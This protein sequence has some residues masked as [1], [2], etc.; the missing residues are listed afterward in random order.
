MADK[1]FTSNDL[2][3]F[4]SR[5]GLKTGAP[6]VSA[7]PA[8]AQP[9]QF[10]TD[11]LKNFFAQKNTQP[12]AKTMPQAKPLVKPTPW[13]KTDPVKDYLFGKKQEPATGAEP[14]I[15]ATD[16]GVLGRLWED[17]KLLPTGTGKNIG[18][19]TQSIFNPLGRTDVQQQFIEQQQDAAYKEETAG[20]GTTGKV[21][22]SAGRGLGENLAG[23]V[24][25]FN[26]A[27]LFG[28]VAKNLGEAAVEAPS[29]M[30]QTLG[31]LAHLGF[32][33]Q[34]A[35]GAYDAGTASV[36][37]F[38]N[39]D[40]ETGVRMAVS[41][42]ISGVMAR[43]GV[44]DTMAQQQV[45]AALDKQA[46]K[47]HGQKFADLK[48]QEKA[49][50]VYEA[51]KQMP[52]H[53][54]L[55]AAAADDFIERAKR[56]GL[57]PPPVSEGL[58]ERL[59]QKGVRPFTPVPGVTPEIFKAGQ[60]H[61]A[62]MRAEATDAN[63]KAAAEDLKAKASR[64]MA[65]I[66]NPAK[67]KLPEAP[68]VLQVPVY[69]PA[70]RENI[71]YEADKAAAMRIIETERTAEL[72]RQAREKQL[73]DDARARQD[74]NEQESAARA[75]RNGGFIENDRRPELHRQVMAELGEKAA[76]S[77]TGKLYGDH[78]AALNRM[79]DGMG[80]RDTEM[81][82]AMIRAKRMRGETL[83][84]EENA[85]LAMQA[86]REELLR[87][88][89]KGNAR[90][91]SILA[92]HEKTLDVETLKNVLNYAQR[93]ADLRSA[94]R[95]LDEQAAKSGTPEAADL[96]A[97]QAIDAQQMA[98][99][100]QT[101][102]DQA[103]AEQAARKEE[104][105]VVP[106]GPNLPYTLGSAT[107][108]H[109]ADGRALKARYA[110]ARLSQ[111]V[112]SHDPFSFRWN[113]KYEPRRMQPRDWENN[114]NARGAIIIDSKPENYKLGRY[115]TDNPTASEGP[116]MI[117]PDGRVAGGNSRLARMIRRLGEGD[118]KSI[119]AEMASQFHRFG[120]AMEGLEDESDP[121]VLVR[122]M[123]DVP[124]TTQD[125][126]MLGQELNRDP[127]IMGVTAEEQ[128]QMNADRLTQEDV[129]GI[130]NMMEEVPGE[131]SLRDV[132][133]HRSQQIL[134]MMVKRGII[135]ANKQAA[136]IAN[137]ELT[138]NAKR[139]LE[140]AI[141]GKVIDDPALV[142]TTPASIMN[143]ID[144]TLPALLRLKSAGGTWEIGDYLK[145]AMRQWKQI[146]SVR[147][148]LNDIGT[149]DDSL[150]DKFYN[151]EEYAGGVGVM[152][153][154][155]DEVRPKPHPVAYAI[156]KALEAKAT[157]YK[158][159][160]DDF[161]APAEGKQ[162]F[163]IAP[164]EPYEVFNDTIGRLG[165]VE[166][167][168]ADWAT[169]EPA[170]PEQ[171]AAV[172]K[173]LEP[174]PAPTK[175]EQK[176]AK[177]MTSPPNVAI[178]ENNVLSAIE[179]GSV[180]PHGLRELFVANPSTSA[181]ADLLMEVLGKIVPNAT[182][183]SLP[184]FLAKHV[185]D[186]RAGGEYTG[187]L[188][189]DYWDEPLGT[190][191]EYTATVGELTDKLQKLGLTEDQAKYV[192]HQHAINADDAS[193][194]SRG[195]AKAAAIA[196]VVEVPPK[197]FFTELYAILGRATNIPW[198]DKLSSD[199]KA[200]RFKNA[201]N[202]RLTGEVMKEMYRFF[203]VDF[204]EKR[205]ALGEGLKELFQKAD[206]KGTVKKG[207]AQFL[208]DGRAIVHLFEA[209]DPSTVLHEFTHVMRRFLVDEN[210]RAALERF[211][212]VEHGLWDEPAEERV[213]RGFE[214]YMEE[215]MA[216]TEELQ[217]LFAKM[218]Q[219]FREIYG[220]I[221]N[222]KYRLPKASPINI[223]LSKEARATFDRW[224]GADE[225]REMTPPPDA[226][227]EMAPPPSSL[228]DVVTA[229]EREEAVLRAN[230][231][232][233]I[234]DRLGESRL[235]RFESMDDA[236]A[237]AINNRL[238]LDGIEMYELPNGQA[239]ANFVPKDAKTLFQEEPKTL[240]EMVKR[241]EYIK[242]LLAKETRPD[243]RER[244]QADIRRL[245]AK[246]GVP[247][248][249]FSPTPE[250]TIKPM[251]PVPPD[252]RPDLK[253]GKVELLFG[254]DRDKET[255]R[256]GGRAD[257]S[258]ELQQPGR[259]GEVAERAQRPAAGRATERNGASAGDGGRSSL[260]G[261]RATRLATPERMRAPAVV[262]AD[263]WAA[264][265]KTLGMPETLPAPT[266]KVD[267]DIAA[268]L[269]FPGQQ[270]VVESTLS[271]LDQFDG[272]IIATPTGTGK[273]YTTLAVV[274]QM[275]RRGQADRVLVLTKNDSIINAPRKG[276]KEIGKNTFKLEVADLPKKNLARMQDGVYATTYATLRGRP[277]IMH[278]AWDLVMLDESAEAANWQESAQG[279]A[280]RLLNNAT[281]KTVYISATPFASAVE[282]GYMGK[283]GMW[284]GG[285]FADWAKQF[286]VVEGK[287]GRLT[288]GN[289]PKKLLKLREQLIERGQFVTQEK[290][291]EG[292]SANFAQVPLTPE[293]HETMRGIITAMKEAALFYDMR[294]NA[295]M[296][297]AVRGNM[298]TF[299]KS[300]L[301]RT[302]LPQTLEIAKKMR[303]QG[304]KVVIFSETRAKVD[305][306]YDFL[307]EA[308]AAS[309]GRL[310]RAIPKLPGVYE[311]IAK[312][313]G[314]DQVANFSGAYSAAREAEKEA[315]DSGAKPILFAT[316]GAGGVG[317]SLHDD[318][319][320]A[321]RAAIYLG[322]PWSGKMFDQA[323]GRAWRYGTKSN[324]FS[325][326]M[327][328]NAMP[329]TRMILTKVAPRL[330][331]LRAAVDGV[332][333]DPMVERMRN[334]GYNREQL[335][336]FQMGAGPETKI[337]D[338]LEM[339]DRVL[340]SNYAD[341]VVPS[342]ESAKHK[343]MKYP[344]QVED[345]PGVIQLFQSDGTVIV[346]DRFQTPEE[347]KGQKV[348]EDIA[349]T[350][351]DGGAVP[352]V[353]DRLS[354][355][356]PGVRRMMA[357]MI[358]P[359]VADELETGGEADP[360]AVSRI[361]WGNEL[362]KMLAAKEAGDISVNSKGQ[363]EMR[364]APPEHLQAVE[365][366]G[367][368][369]V[370]PKE[371]NPAYWTL[372]GRQ[373][374]V[375]VAT[376]A[377]VPEVG[378]KL[379][380]MRDEYQVRRSNVAGDFQSRYLKVLQE[381]R[382]TPQESRVLFLV[383]EGKLPPPNERIA[384]AAQGL[385]ELTLDA[386]RMLKDRGWKG[387]YFADG[388]SREFNFAEMSD[389]PRYAPHKHDRNEKIILKD[390]QTGEEQT[391]TLNDLL[392]K[393]LSEIKR[394]KIIATIEHNT[395]MKR[396]EIEDWIDAKRRRTP[397]AGNLERARQADLPFYR[398]DANVWM[399]YFEQLGEAVARADVFGQ[400]R[401]KLDAVA[402]QIPS[403]KGR[404]VVNQ[405]FDGL[406]SK[407]PWDQQ[408]GK[409]YS[410]WGTAEVLSKM[411]FSA[412]K[413][414]FHLAHTA[415]VMENVGSVAKSVFQGAFS[416]G[417]MKE[418]AQLAGVLVDQMKA[419]A[420]MEQAAGAKAAN[421]MLKY[422][423]FHWMYQFDRITA[424][425]A[426][427]NW[428]ERYAL[429]KLMKKARS[430]D[431]IRTQ[432]KEKFLMDDKSIDA[433]VERGRW[434][435]EDLNRG[436]AALT[437][438]T[439]F[440][441]DPTELAPAW[442]S[443]SKEPVS[444]NLGAV[445]RIATILKGFTFKTAMLIKEDILGEARRGNY[446]PLMYAAM[447]YPAVGE[448]LQGLSAAARSAPAAV[449][450]NLHHNALTKYADDLSD[451]FTD[452]SV[453]KL[454]HRW[455]DD[456]GH[457]TAL[458]MVSEVFDT[459][460]FP[461]KNK[462]AARFK[463][464]KLATDE[465]FWAIGPYADALKTLDAAYHVLGAFSVEEGEKRFQVAGKATVGWAK[466]E[467]PVLRTVFPDKKST[468]TQMAPPPQ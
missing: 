288:G 258:A 417:E 104:K 281:V 466:E 302:R 231:G 34:M 399:E 43:S 223:E 452:P 47:L 396:A 367:T 449:T 437:N 369:K 352:A 35:T 250:S 79:T 391:F 152:T 319:G 205:A 271:A 418:R 446:R 428:M 323:M 351:T 195:I 213:A 430:A 266:V 403:K 332:S 269:I 13:A 37:A 263:K 372:S 112:L 158:R 191:G 268:L 228:S 68:T 432:L 264:R 144:R 80:F 46:Q 41:G 210:D 294:G 56:E 272:T 445:V 75:A 388:E 299:V 208:D 267:N 285:Q 6:A 51:A 160:F 164:P 318:R 192:L 366:G 148:S 145:E 91:E 343:G 78:I 349:Q 66:P 309:D 414:P 237:W 447:V 100:V 462:R 115:L 40:Y 54:E 243:V 175:E 244:M 133:R 348:N 203:G 163:L 111:L 157:E 320:N 200:G 386:Q 342:A 277:D 190:E 429:P 363:W 358:G 151:P 206:K 317:V 455:L 412:V 154:G 246:I 129:D 245:D 405:I 135:P 60:D 248:L 278:Q 63:A 214:K 467:F 383:K 132:L 374:L 327:T 137:G 468:K 110:A 257:A 316:Y 188:A 393:S 139:D 168:P 128:G 211:A 377:G 247:D 1:Q 226:V 95:N 380:R 155:E 457:A 159:A 357:D 39:G 406:L 379:K 242:G 390:P 184:E 337:E 402:V 385:T 400:T 127:S 103:L 283:L 61:L 335:A 225:P 113:E 442:R 26:L 52:L 102:R 313:F 301:E 303:D 311:E 420:M 146:D 227:R 465:A 173:L 378:L 307:A 427:Q 310:S 306:M 114:I 25:A 215:G 275:R 32:T 38:R 234:A 460:A 433:A 143:S 44:Q 232:N 50:V 64:E 16:N 98:E 67:T 24:S 217:G 119:A 260:A 77:E 2:Q 416:F 156:T 312:H 9:K 218:K 23:Q 197:Q 28:G 438:R 364:G 392:G 123:D 253:P 219:V 108:V 329:E 408:M 174:E 350:L 409:W 179:D 251:A 27:L 107:E 198:Q 344:G 255:E 55:K 425:A 441:T 84:G 448:A 229:G 424:N 105:Q 252:L 338:M 101:Q 331:S 201:E 359:Q 397:L 249:S 426:A 167:H 69:T 279:Q 404:D 171:K 324:V 339:D 59:A 284:K 230:G 354:D 142:A 212:G 308:D 130:A 65:A 70:E 85:V 89:A 187:G 49:Q 362:T 181:H 183:L 435:Q 62:A 300:W 413:V 289:D 81:A 315:F 199:L 196:N 131:G 7:A 165:G 265:M 180:T 326:F 453:A 282:L 18:E 14:S 346:P 162:T 58:S 11:D 19:L 53:D 125:L 434:S 241:S 394:Q 436:G 333:N 341:M 189:Q 138:E 221:K 87:G 10:T 356:E 166:V 371:V 222:G 36:D 291:M 297:K 336:A 368:P 361:G 186:V 194:G 365:G 207:A 398:T 96:L 117:L 220:I 305:K 73:A 325:A 293:Q 422:E 407:L 106:R 93:E 345:R 340:L 17:V 204:P 45:S 287:D 83:N 290:S 321:P 410:R 82:A 461:P 360:S 423:G 384:K 439:L 239:F 177:E 126:I 415:V 3:Q 395:G 443:R 178:A 147:A 295:Q 376:Q 48:P 334:L 116:A 411:T 276:L 454:V 355:V 153:F 451:L 259:T 169:M 5:K 8:P 273:S 389:D 21:V 353:G 72:A 224:F 464:Q 261:V 238:N 256:P 4:L 134:D 33:V 97:Q 71:R 304:W 431:H 42:L 375:R 118:G 262:P 15:T 370:E 401:E 330:E 141:R 140:A 22:E 298:A 29:K 176:A 86:K 74:D 94:A 456:V 122:V 31:K 235:K 57:A 124:E 292:F 347:R 382:I 161:A 240:A 185:A 120:I 314:Q 88:L 233:P 150:V 149:K 387:N 440:T 136:Y 109:L 12:P 328:S 76:N 463:V 459:L 209:S 450:G 90:A 99:K 270:E 274:E 193:V 419:G 286:G 444:D 170:S 202:V 121:Y 20:M 92:E 30:S 182:G 280:V 421:A 216:P 236:K 373:N 254:G 172:E 381:N 296:A 458:T 322:P